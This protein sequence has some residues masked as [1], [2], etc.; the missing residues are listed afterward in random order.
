MGETGR[1]EAEFRRVLELDPTNEEAQAGLSRLES[2]LG[3]SDQD[4]R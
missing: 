3:L 2:G 1:A 4:G